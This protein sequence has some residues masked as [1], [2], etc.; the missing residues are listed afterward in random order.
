MKIKA[1]KAAL[2]SLFAIFALMY[3]VLPEIGAS[4]DNHIHSIRNH[5]DGTS[6]KA[7]FGE[8]DAIEA[9]IRFHNK[10]DSLGC[11]VCRELAVLHEEISIEQAND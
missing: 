5:D 7:E 2:I 11:S 3:V 10:A 6:E 8:I 9:A 4:F 1:L